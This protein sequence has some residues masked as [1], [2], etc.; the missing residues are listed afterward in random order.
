MVCLNSST[1]KVGGLLLSQGASTPKL[2]TEIADENRDKTTSSEGDEEEEKDEDENTI[3]EDENGDDGFRPII[4]GTN[5]KC[6]I[7]AMAVVAAA[8]IVI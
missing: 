8:F 3:F 4:F 6:S 5:I 1:S 2:S 7:P